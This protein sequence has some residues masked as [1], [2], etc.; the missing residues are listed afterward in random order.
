MNFLISR[1][2]KGSKTRSAH[3]SPVNSSSGR[4]K[5]KTARGGNS[6]RGQTRAQPSFS[7]MILK[8]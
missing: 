6:K 7:G 3:F 2:R 5:A 1:S 8:P 4:G